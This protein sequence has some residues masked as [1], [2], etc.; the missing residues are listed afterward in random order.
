M[1]DFVTFAVD[2][3]PPTLMMND[4][5]C[6]VTGANAGIGFETAKALAARGAHVRM[7]CRNEQKGTAAVAR[8]LAETDATPDHLK[9]VVCDLASQADIRRVG[10][11]LRA[12]L[13]RL[14]V[15][16]NNAGVWFSKWELTADGSERQFAVNHLAYFLL[17]H[18]LLPSLRAAPEA[19]IVCVSSDSHFKGKMHF[20]DIDLTH[21]YHGLRAYAQSKLAN[22]LFVRE[23]DRR[24]GQHGWNNIA[25]NAVQPGLVKTD[26]GL[27]HTISLHGIAWR[28]R[29]LGGVTPAEGAQTNVFLATSPL[30]RGVSGQYWDRCR[31]K[32]SSVRSYDPG[33]A[34]RLWALSLKRTGLEGYFPEE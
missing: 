25:V 5:I 24:L 13:P 33:D 20:D 28:L 23:L 27:K 29:R 19:R 3:P 14:D 32:R 21:R 11:E 6:L 30:V 10:A 1:I 17:T 22:V 2:Q 12:H 26:I 8:I 4:K 31:P 15:L 7:L 9:V 34:R 18:E 16:V